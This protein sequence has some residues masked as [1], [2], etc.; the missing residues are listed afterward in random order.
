MDSQRHLG[1]LLTAVVK[2]L[3]EDIQILPDILKAEIYPDVEAATP[4][5]VFSLFEKCRDLIRQGAS[6]DLEVTQ[7]EAVVQKEGGLSPIQQDLIVKFWRNQ[8]QDIHSNMYK[9]MVWNNS[10]QKVAWRID[11]KT[12]TKSAGDVNEP[13]AIVELSIGRPKEEAESQ[14]LVRFEMDRDSLARVL[15]QINNIQQQ[16]DT[17]AAAQ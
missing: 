2:S 6:E 7:F 8:K 14:K 13:T 17:R 9:K 1:L 16:I 12:K 3:F 5:G 10:L 11:M 4:E 15:L